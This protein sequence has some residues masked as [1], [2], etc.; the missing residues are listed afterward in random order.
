MAAFFL[1]G[2]CGVVWL[3]EGKEIVK[4]SRLR[5]RK[6]A[7]SFETE[8]LFWETRLARPIDIY[9]EYRNAMPVWGGHQIGDEKFEVS[10]VFLE[11]VTD[12]G[13]VGIAGPTTEAVAYIIASQLQPILLGK[14]PLATELLWDQMH[15]ELVHGRQGEAM[16]AVSVV[17]CAL[18]DIKGKVFD[19]PV[20]KLIGGPTRDK[21]PL[22]AS[23]LG[24]SVED[25]GLVRERAKAA[26]AEGYKA[27]KWFFRHG[28]MSGPEGLAH[29]VELVK[30]LR[31]TLGEGDSIMLDC[32]QSMDVPYVLALAQRI[33]DYRPYWLE[34]CVMPDRI[35]SYR[36]IKDKIDIPL[37]GAEHEY[38]RWGFKRFVDAGALDV[39]QPDIY[40]CGGLSEVLKIASY[41]T[42][43]D[44][45]TIPHGGSTP[46]T[47]QFSLTQSPIHTPFQEY[48]V[49]WNIIL[50]H[51]LEYPAIPED[52]LLS[53][54]DKPGM[55]MTL[56]SD[57]IDSE[58]EIFAS[59]SHLNA[60]LH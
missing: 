53:A 7:G 54:P 41:A 16:W 31:E 52:G 2:Y 25:Y 50:Q 51:F 47:L 49:K 58:E 39:L 1:A 18:W 48:L 9:P 13:V 45:I 23:M 37:S 3:H 30:T 33:S 12:D 35:D 27:Q 40:W 46:A 34:E 42:I 43:H 60:R 59:G 57:K 22:Y 32:W 11:V 14:D 21:V 10:A 24:Y 15:R 19:V 8:G 38:T 17:D 4:I 20:Y 55:N 56:N 28:P 6:L 36:R 26:Q 5:L 29:N 44:L